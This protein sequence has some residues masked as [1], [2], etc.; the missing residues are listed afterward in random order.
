MDRGGT[1]KGR[2]KERRAPPPSPSP[3]SPSSSSSHSS[4]EEEERG[5]ERGRDPYNKKVICPYNWCENKNQWPL[6]KFD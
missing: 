5:G 6:W 3:S 1:D 2:R 4:I